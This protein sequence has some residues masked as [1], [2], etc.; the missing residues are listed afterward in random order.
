MN[1]PIFQIK[2]ERETQTE[3]VF[4]IEPLEQG[5][6]NTIGN[7]LRRVLLSSL[8]GA[9]IT[10]VKI[11]GVRHQFTTIPGLKEDVVELILNIK[12]IRVQYTGEKPIQI[13]LDVTGPGEV[14]AGD[15]KCPTGVSI[16]N[17]DLVLGNLADKK[18]KL[19]IEMTVERGYGYSPFEDR[20]SDTLG[21]IPIDATF[22]PVVRVNQKIESTRV[23]RMTNF[24]KLILEIYTDGTISPSDA[25]KEATKT[26]I[27]Y[28]EQLANPKKVEKAEEVKPLVANETAKLTI[29]ELTLPT[30]IVN[31]LEKSGYKTVED[32]LSASPKEVAKIKNLGS[33]SLKI[34]QA[35]LKEKGVTFGE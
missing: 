27:S 15:I 22:T 8:P 29:E 3:G 33:K 6:G 21:I 32:L 28:F 7:P 10:F 11:G 25:L 26:L 34:I 13:E 16:A 12:K 30:R 5:Y 35:A 18:S 14:K 1:D 17:K 24:D 31:A 19:S 20:K 23:G 4:V 9:A 2:T